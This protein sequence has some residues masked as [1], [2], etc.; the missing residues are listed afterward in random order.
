MK[1]R[2]K[3]RTRRRRREGRKIPQSPVRQDRATGR[4]GGPYVSNNHCS[5]PT[6]SITSTTD[7]PHI[8]KDPKRI[9]KSYDA[10]QAKYD[11]NKAMALFFLLGFLWYFVFWSY[12]TVIFLLFYDEEK[13]VH[14]CGPRTRNS[15]E[16][17][18]RSETTHTQMPITVHH[19]EL[20]LR[21]PQRKSYILLTET[22]R[23]AHSST[24]VIH[25]VTKFVSIPF[26]N[27]KIY[28]LSNFSVHARTNTFAFPSL[29]FPCHRPAPPSVWNALL[30]NNERK[31]S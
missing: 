23:G 5:L 28:L 27:L 22:I 6:I 9:M 21:H 4:C 30:H 25:Q 31:S 18:L 11:T 2:I 10:S 16:R 12:L 17:L 15:L 29:L 20:V 24:A 13:S 14:D 8:G 7:P 3:I 19:S 1:K 26:R